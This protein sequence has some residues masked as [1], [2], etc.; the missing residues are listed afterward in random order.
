MFFLIFSNYE[1]NKRIQLPACNEIEMKTRFFK[2][3]NG[4]RMT[5]IEHRPS[6]PPHLTIHFTI[7][8]YI[9]VYIWIRLPQYK[10]F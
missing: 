6:L 3:T 1:I 8:T 4:T 9:Y 5:S 10:Q 2:I 7:H